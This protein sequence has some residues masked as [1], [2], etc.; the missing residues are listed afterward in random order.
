M[1]ITEV[2]DTE[3]FEARMVWRK[4]GNK[5][6][7]AVRCTSGRRKGRVVSKASQCGAPIDFKKRLTL[8][9]TKA[10]FG[11]RI[12]RKARRSKKYNPISRR[13]A[14]M[15]KPTRFKPRT[16]FKT[17]SNRFPNRKK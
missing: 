17:K 5:V 16:A 12:A 10:K 3:I 1:R 15:N 6:K 9:K 14:Q 8:K 13:V 7:R 4:M 2:D 11:A